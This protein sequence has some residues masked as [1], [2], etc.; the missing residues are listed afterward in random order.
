MVE[1]P[2]LIDPRALSR[3]RSRAG[4]VPPEVV[5]ALEKAAKKEVAD[6]FYRQM[7]EPTRGSDGR[8]DD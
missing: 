3:P 1:I 2:I 5:A 6:I 8:T 4:V 7:M